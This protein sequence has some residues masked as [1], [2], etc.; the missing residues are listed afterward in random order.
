MYIVVLFLP[1]TSLQLMTHGGLLTLASSH[2]SAAAGS[3]LAGSSAASDTN[4]ESAF[5][6]TASSWLVR[7]LGVEG[8]GDAPGVITSPPPT[9]LPL[10]IG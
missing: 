3:G 4:P 5:L 1:L 6:C 9:P 8:S 2:I 7:G 10:G